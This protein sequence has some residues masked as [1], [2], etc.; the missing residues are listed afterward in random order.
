MDKRTIQPANT[1]EPVEAIY[2]TMTEARRTFKDITEH[3]AKGEIIVITKQGIPF[4][5]LIPLQ[6]QVTLP[7]M[8][9]II[10]PD[11]IGGQPVSKDATE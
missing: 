2:V 10:K 9:G 8:G 11:P 7:T 5:Q 3:A 1:D 4:L 6:F